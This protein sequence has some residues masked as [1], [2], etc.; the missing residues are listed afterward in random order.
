MIELKNAATDSPRLSATPSPSAR[1]LS[2]AR[3]TVATAGQHVAGVRAWLREFRSDLREFIRGEIPEAFI[4]GRRGYWHPRCRFCGDVHDRGAICPELR[5]GDCDVCIG[6]VPLDQFG[7]C[8]R[9]GAR[10]RS[11]FITRRRKYMPQRHDKEVVPPA[12]SAS[13]R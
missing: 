3:R 7:N 5:I 8:A 11:H 2:L 9:A 12:A 6:T 13:R 10:W 1:L 4:G